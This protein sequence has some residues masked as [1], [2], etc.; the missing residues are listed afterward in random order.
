VT[1]TPATHADADAEDGE[2]EHVAG[3][4]GTG[5]VGE[6]RDHRLHHAVVRRGDRGTVPDP[7]GDADPEQQHRR[8]DADAEEV[9]G[10]DGERHAD[11]EHDEAAVEDAL[12]PAGRDDLGGDEER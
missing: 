7:E 6:A 2:R 11:A 4:Q 12:E 5:V 10:A 3:Q 1:A 8:E 9:L